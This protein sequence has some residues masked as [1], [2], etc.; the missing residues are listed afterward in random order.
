MSAADVLLVGWPL[1]AAVVA[2]IEWI[3]SLVALS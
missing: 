1:P 3:L 2:R